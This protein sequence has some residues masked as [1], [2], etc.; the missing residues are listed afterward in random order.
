MCD[1]TT[2][3]IVLQVV[4]NSIKEKTYKLV[5][6]LKGEKRNLTSFEMIYLVTR[7]SS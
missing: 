3:N 2:L 1:I 7:K 4:D 6:F 5:I